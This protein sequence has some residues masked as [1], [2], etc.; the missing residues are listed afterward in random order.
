MRISLRSSGGR[1]E[2]ELSGILRNT[3][4]RQ[5]ADHL[6]T[7]EFPDRL[8]IPTRIRVSEQGSKLRLRREG[9]EIQIQRQIAAAFLMP[10]PQ[11][12]LR[13]LGAGEPVIQEGSYAV[14]Q[15]DADGL[16]VIPPETA[17]L[18][19]NKITVVNTSHRGE[20]VDLRERAA[21]LQEAWK[22]RQE[23]PDEIA[24]L[25]QRHEAMVRGGT[26]TRATAAAADQIRRQMF[27]R[28]ADLGIVYGERGDVLPKL[29]ETLHYQVQKPSVTVENVDPEDIDLKRR[30]AKEWRRWANARGPAGAKFRR[31]VREAYRTVCLVCG[32]YYPPTQFNASGVDAAHILPWS[33]YDLDEIYNGLC[34]CKLHHWAFDEAIIRI[35]FSKGRYIAE[36]PDEPARQIASAAPNFSLKK[37]RE[38]LGVIP[39]GRLPLDTQ[40]RPRPQLLDILAETV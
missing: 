29:A 26:I 37:L 23:F 1:G 22:R 33:E 30:T 40:Q 31:R 5:L 19:V 10:T 34:L 17:V 13:M 20:E 14:D 21:M 6:I 15:I 39:E 16:I 2:Y 9:A 24:A 7:L 32:S 3:R 8:L 28:S 35:R 4:A 12:E 25:L 27:E 11:R 36:M 38:N 18:K